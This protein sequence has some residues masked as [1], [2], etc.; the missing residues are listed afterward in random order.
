MEGA[1]PYVFLACLSQVRVPTDNVNDVMCLFDRFNRE[2]T[3][4]LYL[5]SFGYLDIHGKLA[6]LFEVFPVGYMI[7]LG[8][9]SC[10]A[11]LYVSIV[12][13]LAQLLHGQM[14]GQVVY[15]AVIEDTHKLFLY[16]S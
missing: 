6:S 4:Y 13:L 5:R 11:F 12:D 8:P 7:I 2:S 1:S 14:A 10:Y 15:I 3:P 9:K 16:S